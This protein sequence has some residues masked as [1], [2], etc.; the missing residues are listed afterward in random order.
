[1]VVS[2]ARRAGRL[3]GPTLRHASGP[4]GWYADWL[5]M[6]E[7][8]LPE[9]PEFPESPVSKD[10]FIEVAV[11][12]PL[13][14]TFTYR[15]PAGWDVFL[16]QRVLVPFGPRRLTAFIL[17]IHD[18]P[19]EHLD[20]AKLK[21]PVDTLEEE[22]FLDEKLIELLRW[23]ASYYH[24][25]LGEV[26]TGALPGDTNVASRTFFLLTEEGMEA[27][28]REPDAT[29]RAVLQFI[30]EKKKGVTRRQIETRFPKWKASALAGWTRKCWIESHQVDV[31]KRIPTEKVYRLDPRGVDGVMDTLTP[32]S[33]RVLGHFLAHGEATVAEL[34]AEYGSVASSLKTLQ[35]RG[36][37]VA[38]EREKASEAFV[39]AQELV[40]RTTAV[41]LN[42]DQALAV[43]RVSRSIEEEV[44]A[45]A[46]LQGVTGSGK[47]EVYIRLA[48]KALAAGKSVLV[49]VPEIALTPQLIARFSSRLQVPI[50]VLHSALASRQRFDMFRKAARGEARVVIG[51]RSAVFAPLRNLGLIVV[52]EE[53]ETSYKQEEAPRYHG[54][55]TALMRGKLSECP[56]VLGSATPSLETRY[57]TD[58]GRYSRYFLPYRATTAAMAEIQVVDV[59]TAVVVDPNQFITQQLHHAILDTLARKQQIIIYLNRRGYAPFVI[60]PD[61]GQF[62][63]CPNCSV[64]LVYHRSRERLHCHYCAYDSAMPATCV[65]CD[66]V[67][68][69]LLGAGTQRLEE[70]L[71]E[72]YPDARIARMD[73][74]TVQ[75]KDGHQDILS[76]V[77][78]GDIDILVGTQMLT[79][80]FDFPTI[81]LVGVILADAGLSMPDFRAAERTFQTLVQVSGRAGRGDHPGTVIF[82]TYQP[83]NPVLQSAVLQDYERFYA[84]ELG[85]RRQHGFPPFMRVVR[86]LVSSSSDAEAVDGVDSLERLLLPL[87]AEGL[88][89]LGPNSAPIERIKGQYRWHLLLQATSAAVLSRAVSL[90]N[91]ASLHTKTRSVIV[92]VD[93]ISML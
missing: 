51:A 74:D 19:P 8:A 82:Q 10:R 70:S 22:T 54:R 58:R 86:I 35:K 92:D 18:E 66:G 29:T 44:F 77:Q 69:K 2:P 72:L 26:M 91:E 61:C 15:L 41:D 80:G 85:V 7:S 12:V 31:G 11:A 40:G 67:H 89:I 87:E 60:C 17:A 83:E 55:D 68:F 93:P 5:V 14:G 37:L 4:L 73:R 75:R 39:P 32:K 33:R 79:K 38:G 42:V 56:V 24:C 62:V 50:A 13:T 27:S 45:P 47:T 16:G 25:P 20:P 53:H 48:E 78:S 57:N 65:H 43:E 90:V 71:H 36:T 64:S 46:L 76:R 88:R 21:T 84:E 6:D 52:D 1:M 30:G 3:V 34:Q 81:T 59:K 23:V 49:L 28:L 9:S 63:Q